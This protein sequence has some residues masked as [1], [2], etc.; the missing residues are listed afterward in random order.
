MTEIIKPDAA[1]LASV[2]AEMAERVSMIEDFHTFAVK[3]WPVLEGGRVFQDGWA[4]KIIAEHLELVYH[5]TITRLLINLPPRLGKSSLVSVLWPVWCWLNNASMQFMTMSYSEKL[6][7]RDNVRARRLIKSAWFQ[8]RFGELFTLS[9]DQDTKI[10]VDNMQGGY[11]VITSV[12]G[13]VTGE[14]GDCLVAGTK[15]STNKGIINI[16]DLQDSEGDTLVLSY[17]HDKS[18]YCYRKIEAWRELF[19]RENLCEIVTTS[20]RKITCTKGHMLYDVG[21]GYRCAWDLSVGAELLTQDKDWP[22]D[23]VLSVS[24][25]SGGANVYDIQVEGTNNFFANGV[26]V[27]NCLI[28]D[29][30]NSARDTSETALSSALDFFTQVLP[31]RFNDFSTGRMVVV[32]Q[33]IDERDISGHILGA[34]RDGWT[35]LILPME[36]EIG[37]RCITVPLKSTNGEPWADPRITDGE[38]LV[39]ARMN[40]HDVARLKKELAS[41]YAIAGQLQQRPAPLE[42]GIIKRKWIK[43]WKYPEPPVVDYVLQSWDTAMTDGKHSAYTAVTTW[44][45]FKDEHSIPNIMLLSAFRKKMEFPELYE[46]MLRMSKHYLDFNG[47]MKPSASNRFKPDIILVEDKAS[48]ITLIQQLRRLGIDVIK[49]N[50]NKFGDKINRVRRITH[51]VEAGRLWVPG[52]APDYTRLRPFAD[53]MVENLVNFPNADSRDIVDTVAQALL[54]LSTSGWVYHP[55]DL[56][57]N[58]STKYAGEDERA[59]LY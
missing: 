10:R 44:G 50:P 32:Q 35:A 22:I 59:A 49:F 37:R 43:V 1:Y 20:G 5:G 26:L 53:M 14:G 33:R 17:D 21:F 54:R 23:E 38:L 45:V 11:R 40:A 8:E 39:P 13:T 58:P 31:T 55:L 47:D 4:F 34:D 42:G 41:E 27:H 56:E 9:D 2:R 16:E 12:D 57:A 48:G 18:E 3:A 15:V 46:A 51:L 52:M 24:E 7:M 28:L 6:A 19:D 25:I 29:D 30:P 36:F